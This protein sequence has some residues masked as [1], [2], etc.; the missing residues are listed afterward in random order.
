M[1]MTARRELKRGM[2]NPVRTRL[3]SGN[4]TLDCHANAYK[5]SLLNASLVLHADC[6]FA[7]RWDEHLVRNHNHGLE[8]LFLT[9]AMSHAR[10]HAEGRTF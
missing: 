8:V 5:R 4:A 3:S 9:A 6:S 1:L 7:T 10:R 2:R